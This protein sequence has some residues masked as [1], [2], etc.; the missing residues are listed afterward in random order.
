MLYNRARMDFIK[1]VFE[2]EMELY[3]W[4]LLVY[5]KKDKRAKARAEKFSTINWDLCHR[6]LSLYVQR[7]KFKHSLAFMQ[8]RKLLPGAKICD[9]MEIFNGRKEHLLKIA[10]HV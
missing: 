10:H 4:N 3:S 2:R 5:G 7:C 6:I 9:I 8:Y 1:G